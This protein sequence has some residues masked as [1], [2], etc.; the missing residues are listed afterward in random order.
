MEEVLV[1]KTRHEY[2]PTRKPATYVY[3]LSKLRFV[4]FVDLTDLIGVTATCRLI[5]RIGGKELKVPKL[6]NIRRRFLQAVIRAEFS[7]MKGTKKDRYKILAKKYNYTEKG[8][9]RIT[10]H[11]AFV[12]KYEKVYYKNRKPEIKLLD[13]KLLEIM[14]LHLPTLKKFGII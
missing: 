11:D 1:Q 14:Q 13:E 6:T 5:Q 3:Y 10:E 9:M 8:I 7:K 12:S 4:E 2:R